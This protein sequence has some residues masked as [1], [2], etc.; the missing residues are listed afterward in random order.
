[1]YRDHKLDVKHVLRS[2]IRRDG[3]I[4]IVLDRDADQTGQRMNFTPIGT[5]AL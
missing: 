5:P 2:V 3:E 1:L 4:S